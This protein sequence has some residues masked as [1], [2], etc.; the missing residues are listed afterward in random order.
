MQTRSQK[1][2]FRIHEGD[3]RFKKGFAEA[4]APNPSR[5]EA[6]KTTPLRVKKLVAEALEESLAVSSRVTCASHLVFWT[7]FCTLAEIEA[8]SCFE[9]DVRNRTPATI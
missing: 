6:H 1:R 4:K 9:A 2:C 5:A 3:S 7:E 8:A